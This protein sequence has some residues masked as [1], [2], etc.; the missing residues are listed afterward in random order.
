MHDLAPAVGGGLRAA[1]LL[2]AVTALALLTVGVQAQSE[3]DVWLEPSVSGS[4]VE[5]I[6]MARGAPHPGVRYELTSKKNGPA[7]HSATRQSGDLNL[8]CCDPV[9]LSRL[10][11][12]LASGERYTVTLRL[13]DGGEVVL[14]R[15]LVYPN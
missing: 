4:K 11:L 3:L 10:T 15:T 1:L 9:P 6:A 12:R 13:L 8:I 7:G 14:E 2:P 5:I